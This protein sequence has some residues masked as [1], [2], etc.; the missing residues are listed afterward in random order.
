M[1]S[2]SGSNAGRDIVVIR[3]SET[4]V[5][6]C[7][8]RTERLNA[9]TTRLLLQLRTELVALGD[10]RHAKVMVLTGAGTAFCAGAD[11]TEFAG[12]EPVDP[13]DSM[14]RLRLVIA[15]VR[16]LLELEPVT[17]AAVDGP[18][19]GA[20]WG[21]ALA[22]DTCWV[23]DGARFALP[24]VAKGLRV[25]R[26][27]AARL[28]QV[29]GP[30]RAAELIL[31]GRAIDASEALAIGAAGRHVSAPDTATAAAI[32]F[33]TQL[34]TRSRAVL[35]GAVDPFRTMS[36]SGPAPEIEYQWPER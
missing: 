13:A 26:I 9:V 17:I 18:A 36:A 27:V 28:A 19:I 35:R 1:S 4:V 30:V 21:L 10:D 3:H 32:A 25:P 29:V 20:G 22:C 23:G 16:A 11:L 15:C 34:A 2:V 8:D 7:L 31:S 14:A 5:E 12:A 6:I 33:G 24:E